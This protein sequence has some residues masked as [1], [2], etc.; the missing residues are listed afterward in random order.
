[1]PINRIIEEINRRIIQLNAVFVTA[2]EEE[3]EEGE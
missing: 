1:L 3:P 2:A